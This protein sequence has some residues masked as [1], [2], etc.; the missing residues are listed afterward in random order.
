MQFTVYT[1]VYADSLLKIVSAKKNSR[2]FVWSATGAIYRIYSRISREIV[3]KLICKSLGGSTY[4]RGKSRN[5][6]KTSA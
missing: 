3:G 2:I 5:N 4:T 1:H 6:K